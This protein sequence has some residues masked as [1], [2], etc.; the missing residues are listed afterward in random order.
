MRRA[1]CAA[2]LWL[3]STS[4]AAEV[5][6]GLEQGY[7]TLDRD[8][9][10]W[11]HSALSAH[12]SDPRGGVRG[13]WREVSRFGVSDREARVAGTAQQ[14]GLTLTVEFTG[15]PDHELLPEFSAGFELTVPV[16]Q[17]FVVN[18]GSRRAA[19]DEDDTTVLRGGV[20]YYVGAARA[21][22]TA[23]NGRLESGD[24]GTA[25]VVQADWY[26]GDGSRIGAV[27]AAGGE[28]TRIDPDTVVVADVVSAALVGR[29]WLQ[30][31]WGL[32]YALTWTE[33]GDFHTRWGGVLGLLFR[34]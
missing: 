28:A 19:Y 32:S 7:E 12:W 3:A 2:A 6:L 4:A 34:L 5:L 20:E 1:A 14:D 25:H 22:Y 33:Q 18:A 16:G 26:Y 27:A 8:R 23:V 17:G 15:S 11:R 24:S 13:E 31:P 10:E 29:H 21:A 30:G 9:P